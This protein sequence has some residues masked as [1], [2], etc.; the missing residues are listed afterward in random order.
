MLNI[1][2]FFE[3]K[4]RKRQSQSFQLAQ[5]I[6]HSQHLNEYHIS[7]QNI[8]MDSHKKKTMTS[9]D[10]VSSINDTSFDW[11]FC[12]VVGCREN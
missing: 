8:G 5:L 11:L 9:D 6:Y 4:Q 1:N 7:A 3:F 2:A 12:F 10:P